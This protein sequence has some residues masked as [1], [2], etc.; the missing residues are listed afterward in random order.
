M[1]QY[2]LTH[3]PARRRPRRPRSRPRPDRARARRAQRGDARPPAP[4]CSRA[5]CTRRHGDGRAGAGR[6][7]A[8]DRRPVRRGQGARRRVHDGQGAPTSTRR[9]AGPGGS[10]RLTGCRS[11][12][13]RSSDGSEC[14]RSTTRVP[15][16]ARPRRRRAGPRLR[17]HRHRRGRGAGGLR[18]GAARWPEAGCRRARRAGSSPPPGAARSTGSGGRPR[19]RTGT[20]RPRCCTRARTPRRR[21]PCE[22]DRLRLIFTCCHP[23]L[24]PRRAGRA[25]AAAAR[26][27][28]HGRDR[29]GVPACRSRRW[30]SGWCARR[31]RSATRASPTACPARPSCPSGCAP[32]WPS[33]T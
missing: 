8:G 21:A 1:K 5:A 23:A 14:A 25:H 30:R 28:L 4:G 15:R 32:C 9:S 22:D 19:A 31:A 16:G 18:R 20:P 3:L 6:R 27:A 24:A 2:L 26:R 13:G 11:R 10:P 17:R 29:A 7:R 33:C 12:C